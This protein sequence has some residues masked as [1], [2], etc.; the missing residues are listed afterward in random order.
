[1]LVA[2]KAL[3]YSPSIGRGGVGAFL[4]C[5]AVAS[6][7]NLSFFVMESQRSSSDVWF[8]VL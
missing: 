7:T 2:M 3:F 8:I 1:M 5:F 6:I 4:G